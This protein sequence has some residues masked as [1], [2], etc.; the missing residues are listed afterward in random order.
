MASA[1]G[2]Y[3]QIVCCGDLVGY[4]ADPNPCVEWVRE[5]AQEVIRGN[6]DRACCG[7]EN[8][9]WFN[10][11]ARASAI[12]TGENLTPENLAYLRT[13]AR[14]P[15][16]IGASNVFQILHGSPLDEDEYVIGLQEASQF[17]G[18]LEWPLS[19]FG[20]THL[21]GGFLYARS[22]VKSLAAPGAGEDS[23]TLAID[24]RYYYLVNPGSVGQPRDS[25]PRAGY[26]IYDDEE[27][28]VTFHRAAY[29]IEA[30]QRKIRAAGLPPILAD[31]LAIG[32]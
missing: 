8:L 17:A 23:L 10:P 9:E 28:T 22:R 14:G 16:P 15:K 32:R 21:Q 19:F 24:P 3:G 12:W 6:H 31:R 2:E 18:Y 13:L 20:H 25:D 11:F 29:D 27:K 30:A 1:A 26:A 5:N 7:Q 4:G